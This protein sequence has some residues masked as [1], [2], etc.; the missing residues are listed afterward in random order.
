MRVG[1][2]S[3]IINS[4]NSES[5]HN[6]SSIFLLFALLFVLLD[7]VLAPDVEAA[8]AVSTGAGLL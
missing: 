8:D 3:L 7:A 1:E 5:N 6:C 2:L 4:T